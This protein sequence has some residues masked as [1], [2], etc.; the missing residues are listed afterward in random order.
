MSILTFK[1]IGYKLGIFQMILK[2][3]I[4]KNKEQDNNQRGPINDQK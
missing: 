1:I 3:W 2:I 4:L